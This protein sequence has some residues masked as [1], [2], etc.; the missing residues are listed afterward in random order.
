[1]WS[2]P[3]FFSRSQ[4]KSITQGV[5]HDQDLECDNAHLAMALQDTPTACNAACAR[6]PACSKV[7]SLRL[8]ARVLSITTHRAAVVLYCTSSTSYYSSHRFH[9]THKQYSQDPIW[10][11]AQGGCVLVVR[12]RLDQAAS[13]AHVA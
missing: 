2:S 7:H 4:I 6:V 13:E 9:D 1:M 11:D 8:R 5:D 12:A 3:L 10:V